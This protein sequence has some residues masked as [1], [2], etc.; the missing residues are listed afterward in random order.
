MKRLIGTGLT[1]LLFSGLL[2]SAAK[3]GTRYDYQL[4]LTHHTVPAST[5][6]PTPVTN[7]PEPMAIQQTDATQKPQVVSKQSD[8][9]TIRPITSGNPYAEQNRPLYDV[10]QGVILPIHEN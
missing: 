8:R 3:A 9:N 4:D 2:A 1:V 6:Q 5:Q 10:R 7:L